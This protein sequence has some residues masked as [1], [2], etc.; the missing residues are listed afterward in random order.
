MDLTEDE[1][2]LLA[3]LP[4][5]GKTVSNPVIQARLKWR[6]DKYWSVRDALVDKNIIA[7]GRGRGGTLRLVGDD[8]VE[9]VNMPVPI[10]SAGQPSSA[11]TIAAAV[12]R[13]LELYEPMAAVLRGD[14]ARDRRA[15]PLSVEVTALQGRRSTGGTWSRPDIVGIEIKTY[16]YVPG[17]YLE[18]VTFEVKASD[19]INVQAVYEALAHRRSATHSYVLLHVPKSAAA[20]LEDAVDDVRTVARSHGIGLVVAGEPNDYD[21]WEELEEARRVEPD[22]GRLDNFIATQL[23]D[24]TRNKIARG[25]R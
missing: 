2:A 5:N 22:P 10:E 25:L 19:G 16:E 11:A 9:T 15:N 12:R 23:S 4:K 24:A 1:D 21:N 20:S 6:E 17:K 8:S 14:W 13:E 7:R 3:C 18:V